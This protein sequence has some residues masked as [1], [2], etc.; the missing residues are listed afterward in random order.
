MYKNFDE[1]ASDVLALAKEIL[2]DKLIYI[3]S[4]N[5]KQQI[6]LKLSDT[7]TSILVTEG[8]VINLNE[9]LCNRIDFERNEPLIYEDISRETCL[10]GLKRTLADVNI[11]A[12]LGIP[13]SLFDGERFGTLCVAHHEASHFDKKSVEML[14]RIARMFSYYLDLERLAYRDSLTGLY[15]RQYLYKYFEDFSVTEGVLFFLDLDGFKKVNDV[16]G[17]ETGD[18]VLK[19]VSLRLQKFVK[20]PNDDA[21]AVRL[22]GD[23][24]IINLPRISSTEEISQRAEQLINYLNTWDTEYQLSASIGIVP[25]S[26]NG[27]VQL[28]TL[29]KNAD[30]ALYRAKAAGKNNYKI[31]N[32]YC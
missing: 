18:L 14:Q 3:N 4:L 20:E 12:Y 32:G 26:A 30:N 29:L 28:N 27:G 25:Y 2:P 11:N 24:F 9:T 6:I 19:E 23:E 16:Y 1:L 21:F 8:M 10:N 17:H 22:G 15:N 13:I 5:D 31:F 7:N